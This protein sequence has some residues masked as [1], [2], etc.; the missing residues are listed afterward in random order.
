MFI[1]VLKNILTG[2]R[3][4]KVQ[5]LI[6]QAEFVDGKISGG[7]VRDK[8]NLELAPET[9]RYADVVGIVEMAVREHMEFNMTAFPRYMTRPI[10]S[11]YEPG[12]FY[13]QHV[14]LPVMGF[15]SQ[16]KP[17]N[18][19]LAPLGAGYV[20]SDLSMTLFLAPPECYDG[21]DLWFD[22]NPSPVQVKLEAGSAVIYP[23]GT[24]HQVIPVTRGV[25]LAA[26]FWIQTMFPIESQRQ[27]V[28]DAR[29]LVGMLAAKPESPELQLAQDS[30]YNLCRMFAAV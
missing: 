28:C 13:K 12:M 25:R 18:R 27:A 23:T 16:G 19:G 3:L 7:T 17:V 5:A 11:R 15:L 26:V 21:G 24:R 6:Q 9:D 1:S 4:A 20:R 14:D 30:F 10:I 22:S 8:K 2:D 29:K